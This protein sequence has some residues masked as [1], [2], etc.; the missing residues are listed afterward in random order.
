MRSLVDETL[1]RNTAVV[2]TSDQIGDLAEI[3]VKQELSLPVRDA[4]VLFRTVYLG[5]KNPVSDFLVDLLAP[6]AK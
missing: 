5:E 4:R 1:S 6:D 3:A 2:L